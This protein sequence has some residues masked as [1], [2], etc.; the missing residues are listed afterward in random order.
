MQRVFQTAF[1]V[2][3]TLTADLAFTW[4]VPFDCTLIAVS[5]VASDAN[6]FGVTVGSSADADGYMTKWASGV[7]GT[8]VEKV[9]RTDFDGALAV[10]QFPHIVDGT[11]VKVA[12]DFNYNGGGAAQ[13]SDDPT[14]VLTFTEG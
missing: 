7:S 8:P 5:A 11:I 2:P 9:A 10:S 14:I 12:V 13:A 6:A 1:H 3:A 4:T